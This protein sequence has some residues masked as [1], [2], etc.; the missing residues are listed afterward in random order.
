MSVTNSA[1]DPLGHPSQGPAAFCMRGGAVVEGI[2]P[3]VSSVDDDDDD[4][5]ALSRT[6]QWAGGEATQ[7]DRTTKEKL[8]AKC[9]ILH[10]MID[11]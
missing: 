1:R 3:S 9:A 4:A 8:E 11:S 6:L 2:H 7:A 5:A 10:S